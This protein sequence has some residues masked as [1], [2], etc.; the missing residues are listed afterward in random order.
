MPFHRPT[1]TTTTTTTH[2]KV[3]KGLAMAVAIAVAVVQMATSRQ[4]LKGQNFSTHP[5]DHRRLCLHHQ[6]PTPLKLRKPR[7][8]NRPPRT[9]VAVPPP[10]K[11]AP[12]QR[13]QQLLLVNSRV[14]SWLGLGAVP[15]N[16]HRLRELEQCRAATGPRQR[17]T[18]HLKRWT[19]LPRSLQSPS[20]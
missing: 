2:P 6:L 19:V 18:P 4:T 11:G 14:N 15:E 8:K 1:T 10:A 20:Q 9:A 3:G 7:L 12:L 5:S 16:R 17:T 13:P